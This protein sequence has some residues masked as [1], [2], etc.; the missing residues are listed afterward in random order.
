MHV[1]SVANVGPSV[2]SVVAWE[3][4]LPLFLAFGVTGVRVMNDGTGD[5]TFELTNAVRR[6]L[7]SRELSGPARFLAAGP[8]VDGDPPLGSTKLVVRTVEEG[9]KVVQALA[10]NGA[11][12]IK[13]YENL[14]RKAYFAI[15]DEARLRGIPVDGH[16]PFRVTP[17]EAAEAGQ[18]TVEH[19]E[20]LAAACSTKADALRDQ[21]ARVLAD[22]DNLPEREQ[23]LVQFR[24]YRALYDSRDPAACT[25]AIEAFRRHGVA[26]TVDLVA[27]HHV[28]HAEEVLADDASMRLVP[29]PI[30]RS[31]REETGSETTRE[32][33]SILRPILP[34]ELENVRLLKDAGVTLLAATDVGVPL[35]ISGLGMHRELGRLVEAGLTP[36][37]ALRTATLNPARVLG[38]EDSLGTVEAGKLADLVLL[39]ASP[40][41]DIRNTRRIRAVVADG[42][43][44]RRADLDRLLAQIEALN[45]RL[46]DRELRARDTLLHLTVRWVGRGQLHPGQSDSRGLRLSQ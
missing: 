30:R 24:H 6:R 16:V 19:P 32:F 9:R 18:R 40:L 36:L 2:E 11:D 12:L 4:H 5:V 3:W 46:Q 31:W 33:Q 38:L 45:R 10:S 28:V 1:H 13:V 29:E 35:Q 22:Y 39:D 8:S 15:L 34:L 41:E 26:V 42:R 25:S 7:A 27:Y 23:F 44:Y 37:E 17:V 14:S 43:V 20:V 21:F